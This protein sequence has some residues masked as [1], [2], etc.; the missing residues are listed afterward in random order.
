MKPANPEM[1]VE[2]E[3]ASA[4]ES[5]EKIFSYLSEKGYA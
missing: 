2:T 3:K 4:E 5:A 1:A